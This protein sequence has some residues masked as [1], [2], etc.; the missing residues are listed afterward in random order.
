MDESILGK[1]F[2]RCGN[3]FFFFFVK[4]L[5]VGI[6]LKILLKSAN[7]RFKNA[8]DFDLYDLFD[9]DLEKSFRLNIEAEAKKI[10]SE[11]TV[12]ELNS[13]NLYSASKKEIDH[14]KNQQ[15]KITDQLNHVS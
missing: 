11:I 8:S 5:L 12:Q 15:E 9:F 3:G 10:R 13:K 1:K 7:T 4:V 14:L 6:S 2:C